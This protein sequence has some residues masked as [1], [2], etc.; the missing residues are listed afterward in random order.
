MEPTDEKTKSNEEAPIRAA[1]GPKQPVH[2]GPQILQLERFGDEAIRP[3]LQP[4]LALYRRATRRHH[5]DL[6]I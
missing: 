5:Q 4:A 6:H 2:F 1:S 3:K